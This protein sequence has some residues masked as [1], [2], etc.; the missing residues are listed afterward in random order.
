[1]G[2]GGTI[3]ST[4]NIL[5]IIVEISSGIGVKNID[6]TSLQNGP[7][8]L[9]LVDPSGNVIQFLSYE[10]EVIATEG[11]AAG[12]T[13]ILLPTSEEPAVTIGLSMQLTGAGN[14]YTDF[15]WTLAPDTIDAINSGQTFN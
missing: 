7:D 11:P 6:F 15:T 4:E 1:N 3:I 2:S 10:D 14:Q 8:A 9:A 5:G 13:S 12:M